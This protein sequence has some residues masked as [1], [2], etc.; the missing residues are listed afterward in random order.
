MALSHPTDERSF[1]DALI[2]RVIDGRYRIVESLGSGGMGHVYR[3]VQIGL[4]RQIA[5]KVLTAGLA[6]ARVYFPY[7]AL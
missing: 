6:D 4:D 5:L 1:E 2:G 7:R 3:A